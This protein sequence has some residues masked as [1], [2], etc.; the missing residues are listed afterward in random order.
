MDRIEQHLG[1]QTPSVEVRVVDV[2]VLVPL[3]RRDRML[4]G[5]RLADRLD[6]L[7]HVE[8]AVDELVGKLVEQLRIGGWVAGADVIDRLDDADAEQVAP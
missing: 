3:V 7:L 5:A 1:R 2:V 4:I 6:E 8:V